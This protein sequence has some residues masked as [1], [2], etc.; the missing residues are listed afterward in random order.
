MLKIKNALICDG[1]GAPAFSGNILVENGTIAAVGAVE[2]QAEQVIDAH[3]MVA[4]PGFVDVHRHLDFNVLTN[5]DFGDLELAQG[6]TTGVGGNC[7]LAPYPCCAQVQREVYDFIRPCLGACG[8]DEPLFETVEQ[9]LQAVR[10]RAPAI[11]VGVLA[12]TGAVKAAV[13]GFS[14][15]P[16]TLAEMEQ[17]QRVLCDALAQGALGISCG[18]MYTP[19]CYSSREEFIRLLTPA[20]KYGR[21]LTSHMRGEGDSLVESVAEVIDIAKRAGLALNIS[22]FKSVGKQNWRR[23]IYKAIELIEN[24][25]AAGNP[26]TADFYPYTGGSTTLLSLVP[27]CFME[28]A[29]EKTLG[30]LET[31]AGRAQFKTEL[32]K[33]H[34]GWDNMVL[35]IGWERIVISGVTLAESREYQGKSIAAICSAGHWDDPADFVAQLLVR[36]RGQVSIIVMSMCE[37]DLDTIAQLPYTALISDSLYGT[38]ENPH[39]RLFASFPKLLRAYVREKKLLTLEQAVHKMTAMPAARFAMPQKGVLRPGADADI[40][41]FALADICDKADFET[42]NLLAQGMHSVIVRGGVALRQG[43]RY[44]RRG[45]VVTAREA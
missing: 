29:A 31:A 44:E 9:Y 36:E 26:V 45:T 35:D 37:E 14:K 11:N 42:P 2:A 39:P 32:Y 17:A 25:R 5:P 23:E 22:H 7:G 18:I 8:E 30:K 28:E 21:V 19:E 41:L 10:K 24:E 3:G 34:P 43:V 33:A 27:P 15:T 13:K 40:N 38:M 6:V 20:A 1:T 16:Y 12:A 4:T